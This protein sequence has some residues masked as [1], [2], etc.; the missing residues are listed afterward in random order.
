MANLI[1]IY[2]EIYM[3]IKPYQTLSSKEVFKCRFFS[4]YEE[5]FLGGNGKRGIYYYS[6]IPHEF[7]HTVGLDIE[8]KNLILV[9]QY[10][11]PIKQICIDVPGGAIGENE[12]KKDAAIR[13]FEEETGYS[14]S[15]LIYLGNASVE[16]A[17]SDGIIHEFLLLDSKKT[18]EVHGG[19]PCEETEVFLLPVG[20]AWNYIRENKIISVHSISTLTKA[21][22]YLNIKPN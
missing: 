17:R 6:K 13:E 16:S 2:F 10:R 20:E 22:L 8:K 7:V 1:N 19:E 3:K 9:Q 14:G 11:Y 21:L 15:E 4:L 5:E 12:N 18:T